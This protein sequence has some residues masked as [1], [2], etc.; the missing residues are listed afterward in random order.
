[1]SDQNGG[2]GACGITPT[3][4]A[5]PELPPDEEPPTITAP[6]DLT[7]ECAAEGAGGQQVDLGEPAVADDR[8]AALDVTNDAPELFGLGTT[9]V[10]WTATDDAGN[11]AADRQQVTIVDTAPPAFA[12]PLADVTQIATSAEGTPVTL[13]APVAMDACRGPVTATTTADLS[14][15][16]IGDHR[17]T[18]AAQDAAGNTSRALQ[19]VHV[20]RL[21][22]DLDVDGDVDRHDL[23]LLLGDLG[24]R[25]VA[26]PVLRDFD[27]DGDID[28]LDRSVF[29]LIG[30]GEGDPRDLDRNGTITIAD[31]RILVSLCTVTCNVA[32]TADPGPDRV[33]ECAAPTGTPTSLDASASSDLNADPLTFTWRGPFPEG[34]GIVH[35]SPVSVTLGLGASPITLVANDRFAD[36]PPAAVTI[37]VKDTTAPALTVPP[38]LV[39]ACSE[40]HADGGG[41]STQTAAVTSWL[42][43]AT[44]ADACD[45]RPVLTNDAPAGFPMG[46]TTV[47]FTARDASANHATASS[48]VQVV[49]AFGGFQ[50]PLLPDG[51]AVVRQSNTGRTIPIKFRLTCGGADVSA[52]SATLRVFKLVDAATG[53]V[54]VTEFAQDAGAANDHGDRFRYDSTDR[55][56]VYNLS[57]VGL[58]APATYRIVVTLD[59]GTRQ[60]VQF[61]LR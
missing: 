40:V 30:S 17:I 35:G 9:A 26:E 3:I 31:A 23:D 32:P 6:V 10:V 19:L 55:Q 49:Y 39:I 43:A 13:T 5:A 18:W 20:K 36:S 37:T 38:D 44:V 41:G 14:S 34:A 22:G 59:D 8:D 42:A 24:E 27:G 48:H 1:V 47:Q 50:K 15:L 52:A 33:L 12:G 11:A 16:S 46:N 4:V 61:S 28:D 60:T 57:T 51:S 58:A 45:S 29:A 21:R 7:A 53:T 2:T 54:D 25:A 56:Y